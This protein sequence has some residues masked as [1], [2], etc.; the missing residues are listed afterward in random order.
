MDNLPS[1]K[2]KLTTPRASRIRYTLE[3]A[4]EPGMEERLERLKSRLQRAKSSLYITPR[5]PMGNVLLVEGLLDSFERSEGRGMVSEGHNSSLFTFGSSLSSH[6]R[7]PACNVATQTDFC[8]QYDLPYVLSSGENTTGCFDVHTAS[9]PDEAYFIASTDATK[10][11]LHTMARYNGKCPLCGFSLDTE[12]LGFLRHGHAARISL[13]CAAG[14]SLR[15][16]SSSVISGKFT[17]NLRYVTYLVNFDE[18][19]TNFINQVL[20]QQKI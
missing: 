16:F 14:H 8:G 13:S 7:P 15:W 5:T 1:K 2:A 3:L 4:F 6:D 20:V 10:Q 12:S 18:V 19:D 9:K 17:V 11:I